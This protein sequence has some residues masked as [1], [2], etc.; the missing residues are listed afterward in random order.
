MIGAPRRS[1]AALA[2]ILHTDEATVARLTRMRALPKPERDGY[3]MERVA[4][5]RRRRPWLDMLDRPMSER[6]IRERIDPRLSI[7]P[8]R[9][10][11]MGGRRYVTPA[12]L[13]AAL[14]A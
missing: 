14:S 2:S 4:A 1:T 12:A 7:P 3:D 10:L 13:F 5:C 9:G 11:T 6:E 8:G